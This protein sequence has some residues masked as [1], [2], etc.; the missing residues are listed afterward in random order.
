MQ[1]RPA[2][3]AF[4]AMNRQAK[5]VLLARQRNRAMMTVTIFLLSGVGCEKKEMV[6]LS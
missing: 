4:L 2:V 6:L 1:A 5:V 3:Q